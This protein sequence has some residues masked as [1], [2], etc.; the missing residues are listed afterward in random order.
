MK[1]RF[2]IFI[3]LAVL[4]GCSLSDDDLSVCGVDCRIDYT[5]RLQTNMRETVYDVLHAETDRSLADTLANWLA[6]IFS[7]Q[8]HDV[9]LSFYSADDGQDALRHHSTEVVDASSTT[10]TFY[11]PRENYYHLAVVNSSDNAGVRL[12]GTEH[13]ATYAVATPDQDTLPS[14]QSAVYT[15]RLAINAAG[16]AD[17]YT[18][19]VDLY[20]T[21][22]AVALALDSKA[23]EMRHIDAYLCGTASRF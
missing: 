13:S 19:T 18:Y 20:M 23:E 6:P 21:S 14:M 12:S 1:N 2:C 22:C 10:F 4:S 15:A 9:E 7:A 16:D 3:A 11:L 5:M 8:A 17:S